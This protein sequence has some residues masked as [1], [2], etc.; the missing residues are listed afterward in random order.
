MSNEKDSGPIVGQKNIAVSNPAQTVKPPQKKKDKAAW[1]EWHKLR[2]Q[3]KHGINVDDSSV[4][5]ATADIPSPPPDRILTRRRNFIPSSGR[6]WRVLEAGETP[7][8]VSACY[9]V[10]DGERTYYVGQTTNLCQRLEEHGLVLTSLG[11][12][13]PIWGYIPSAIIKYRPGK[14][15][16]DW[17]M[18]EAR[19]IRRLKPVYN[20][21]GSD[22]RFLME[23]KPVTNR[24]TIKPCESGSL[25]SVQSISRI[26]KID[27][28]EAYRM[29][30]PFFIE[31]VPQSAIDFMHV[32]LVEAWVR[33]VPRVGFQS[34]RRRHADA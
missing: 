21:V 24:L 22:L 11:L 29:F 25:Y 33:Q 12:N 6:S 30:A 34:S 31:A 7:P 19:L 32:R 4:Q 9:V 23:T 5:P 20:K 15:Y 27:I 16:G 26:W 10:C 2:I 18:V 14:R 8:A 17:L 13:S 1:L 28:D 3:A